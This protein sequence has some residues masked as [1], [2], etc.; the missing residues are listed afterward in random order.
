MTGKK[1]VFARHSARIR[2]RCATN[3]N[4]INTSSNKEKQQEQEEEEEERTTPVQE[5]NSISISIRNTSWGTVGEVYATEQ[6]RF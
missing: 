5:S 4:R 1:G 6:P 2:P 3:N